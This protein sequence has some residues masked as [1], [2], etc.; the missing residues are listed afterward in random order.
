MLRVE[1]L[2]SGDEVLHGHI[3]DSN[4]AWLGRWLFEHGAPLCGRATVGDEIAALCT[5]IEGAARRADVLI[6]NGGLGPTS[7]DLSTQAAAQVLGVA[8]EESSAWM[9]RMQAWFARRGRSMP[10]SNRKQAWLP[11]GAEVLDNPIGTACGF[12]VTLH[13]CV[14]FFTPGVP[15]EF[16]LMVEQQIPPRLRQRFRLPPPPLCLRLSTFGR[17]ESALAEQLETLVLPSDCTLGYRSASPIIELKL[18]G[19]AGQ[20]AAMEVAWARIRTAVA[21]N[22]LFDGCDGV[23]ARAAAALRHAGVRLALSEQFSAG[24]IHCWLRAA[25]APLVNGELLAHE[26][27]P[28]LEQ[29]MGRARMLSASRAG[30]LTLA[31]G[32][33]LEDT[34]TLALHTP[35]GSFGQTLCFPSARHSQALRREACATLALDMLCRYLD[36]RSPFGRYEWPRCVERR[37]E[38]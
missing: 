24:L 15:S 25:D 18:T 2:S 17:S 16:M 30:A 4:A 26:G 10:L 36:G 14:I 33:L 7:D 11:S 34:L 1:M 9:A 5:A 28:T 13:E 19:P 23:A 32:E 20:A 12:A 21:E 38:V 3:L 29:V 37:E 8:L 6:V 22:L 31:S 35:Q 27:H